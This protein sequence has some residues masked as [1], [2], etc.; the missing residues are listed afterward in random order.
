MRIASTQYQDTMNSALQK[1]AAQV[2]ALNQRMASGQRLLV[3]SD[4]PLTSV[5]LSRLNREEAAI[6]QYRDN[7]GALKT[8]LQQSESQLD[9]M[10]SD[11]QQ[12]RDM[13]VGALD[14][15]NSSS[16]LAARANPLA[17]LRDSLLYAA[18]A[19]DQE[20]RYVFSGTAST[21]PTVT[22]DPNAP[23]GSRYTYT[24]NN[25]TQQV[26][27]SQGVT[28]PANVSV[29]EMA[30]LLNQLDSVVATLQ[31]PNVNVSD[32][33]THA[34]VAAGLDGLDSAMDAVG[35]TIAQLGGEQNT[36]STLDTNHANVSLSNQQ[37]LI[38]LGQLDYGDAAIQLTNYTTA[39]EATQKAYAKVAGLSLFDVL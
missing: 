33:A 1:A 28:Q 14:G 21:T 24:G 38:D 9:G 10:T 29:P 15:S 19:K 22:Y 6:S 12:A 32:P 3:P 23:L 27:V 35:T 18:N 20:G 2:S 34:I 7:I 36:L 13:L 37:A 17:A 39:L 11:M 31:T 8:R 30:A 4:D 16:D 25:E 26:V 5:R